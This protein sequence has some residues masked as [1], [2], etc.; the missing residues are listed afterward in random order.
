VF[1]FAKFLITLSKSTCLAMLDSMFNLA[2]LTSRVCD[3]AD[4]QKSFTNLSLLKNLSADAT[5]A[6]IERIFSR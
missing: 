5:A 4:R 2:R 6:G 3:K 1:L